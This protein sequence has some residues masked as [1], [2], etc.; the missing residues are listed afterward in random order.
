MSDYRRCSSRFR[1]GFFVQAGFEDGL[2]AFE[3]GAADGER[4]LA[5]SLD[6]FFA[7]LLGKGDDP[8]AGTKALLRVN[9]L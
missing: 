1:Q 2:D 4:P 8:Q 9:L 6:A 5:G 3:A 7:E